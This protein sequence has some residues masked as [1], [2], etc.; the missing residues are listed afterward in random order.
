[1]SDP[2]E[3]R[4]QFA[5][6]TQHPEAEWRLAEAALLIAAE[7]D[8]ALDPPSALAALDRWGEVFAARLEPD[9]NALQRLARLRTFMYDEL[10]FHGDRDHYFDPRNSLLHSVLER[11]TGIPL[12]LAIV[13]IELGAHAG[14]RL[15]GVGLP[16]HFLVR[17]AGEPGDLLLDPFD[18]AGSV[19]REDAERLLAAATGGA[20]RLEPRMLRSI[21]PRDVVSRLLANLK[22]SSLRAGDLAQALS[23]VE[24]LQMLHPEDA[25]E[26]RDQGLLLYEL[27][28]LR[29]AREALRDYLSRA[30]DAA[31]RE[32]VE[33][34][35]LTIGL[36]LDT[37]G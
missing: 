14:M 2:S 12:T 19:H 29:E 30:A 16:G 26:R 3:V 37:A 25:G 15:E 36:M 18:R 5:R 8:P 34:R 21:G 1:M 27:D 32:A 10:G 23:A 11:R 20:M 17:L 7:S 35:L 28:R 4:A 33:A 31:D 6:M 24:R 22:M 13:L 9:W